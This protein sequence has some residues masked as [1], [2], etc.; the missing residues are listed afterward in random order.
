[1]EFEYNHVSIKEP[2]GWH[3]GENLVDMDNNDIEIAKDVHKDYQDLLVSAP[4]MFNTLQYIEFQIR[5]A[6]THNNTSDCQKSMNL[7]KDAVRDILAK[8]EGEKDD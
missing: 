3:E 5:M 7:I 2:F 6:L 1:M 8:A 4:D